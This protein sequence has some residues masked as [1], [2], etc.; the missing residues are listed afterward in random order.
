LA[1]EVPADFGE[2]ELEV[3]F[4]QLR[5]YIRPAM[6]RALS[7]Y[8]NNLAMAYRLGA[9]SQWVDGTLD[10]ILRV[11]RYLEEQLGWEEEHQLVIEGRHPH[12]ATHSSSPRLLGEGEG[13]ASR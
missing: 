5:A 10:S 3:Y 13:S 8:E 7:V 12:S 9:E 2:V 4:E 6:E 1:T 11:H